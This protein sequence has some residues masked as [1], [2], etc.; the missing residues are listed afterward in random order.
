VVGGGGG[1][2]EG[3]VGISVSFEWGKKKK[4]TWSRKSDVG[5]SEPAQTHRNIGSRARKKKTRPIGAHSVLRNAEKLKK[6]WTETR[7]RLEGINERKIFVLVK[8]HWEKGGGTGKSPGGKAD[9]EYLR[10]RR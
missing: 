10:Q 9:L 7:G 5:G 6:C 1:R 4:V 8:T 3:Q 2:C